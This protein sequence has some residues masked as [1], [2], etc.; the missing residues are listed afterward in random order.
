MDIQYHYSTVLWTQR[1]NYMIT[2]N[3]NEYN[4]STEPKV[5]IYTVINN[6]WTKRL[7]QE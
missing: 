7:E 1:E 5:Y 2:F 6:M 3:T 4:K